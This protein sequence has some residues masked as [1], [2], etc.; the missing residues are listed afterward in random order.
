LS[1]YRDGMG[2][3][4]RRRRGTH[5]QDAA[6][7]VPPVLRHPSPRELVNDWLVALTLMGEDGKTPQ[8]LMDQI[9]EVTQ[10]GRDQPVVVIT[11]PLPRRD[12]EAIE[13]AQQ[14]YASARSRQAGVHVLVENLLI[15]WLT[16]ATGHSRSEILQRL[17][18]TIET[19]LPPE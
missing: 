17:A 8:Q 19:T 14:W 13:A 18:L 9:A 11:T 15:G 2:W 3:W 4:S 7:A 1:R 10:V 12:V 5:D 16:E 6:A